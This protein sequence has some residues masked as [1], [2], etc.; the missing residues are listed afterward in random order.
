M[1]G[2]S[3]LCQK[4]VH[5]KLGGG[6]TYAAWD[7]RIRRGELTSQSLCSM[8]GSILFSCMAAVGAAVYGRGLARSEVLHFL[9]VAGALSG[10]AGCALLICGGHSY[11]GL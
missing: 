7:G 1:E 6:I 9:Q 4:E 8:Y 2:S 3:S 11:Q 10:Q 5:S